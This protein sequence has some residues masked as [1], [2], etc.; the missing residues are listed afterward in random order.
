[1]KVYELLFT[2]FFLSGLMQLSMVQGVAAT[3]ARVIDSKA[4]DQAAIA[5]LLM[6]AALFVTYDRIEGLSNEILSDDWVRIIRFSKFNQ[7]RVETR[8]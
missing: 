3:A 8:V 6:L 7:K 2:V 5:C 1:M 4:V